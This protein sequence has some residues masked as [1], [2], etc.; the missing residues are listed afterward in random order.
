M[1]DLPILLLH[2]ALGSADQLSPLEESL[3]NQFLVYRLGFSGHAG[4][5]LPDVP[6]GNEIFAQ[7]VV[8][9]L[10]QQQIKKAH[11][12]G[13]SMGGYVGLYVA[14]HFSDRIASVFTLGTKWDWTPEVVA[15]EVKMLNPEKMEEKVPRFA[16]LL[17]SRHAPVDWKEIVRRTARMMQEFGNGAGLTEA[18]FRSLHIPVSIG[19]GEL[20]NMVSL[21]ESRRIAEWLPKG[22]L[23]YFEGV[24]HPIEKMD[25]QRLARSISESIQSGR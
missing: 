24:K 5:P 6:F 23:A 25:V 19:I 7:D 1:S 11:I 21:E 9:F 3:A 10:D 2:G 16:D 4:K 20:D 8:K 13:H 15:R 22:K 12:F 14:H 17:A 18:D